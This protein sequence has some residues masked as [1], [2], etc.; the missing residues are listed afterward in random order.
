[1]TEGNMSA[2]W[3]ADYVGVFLT[4]GGTGTF[5]FHYMPAPLEASCNNSWGTL[6]MLKV[7]RDYHVQAYFAQYFAAQVVTRK[8]VQPVDAVHRVFPFS[9]DVRGAPAGQ[10]Q[11]AGPDLGLCSQ[12]SS[13]VVQFR[14]GLVGNERAGASVHG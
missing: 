12:R 2:K 13:R 9:S 5:F 1:M 3:L 8:W 7:D 11:P 4:G 10:C 14:P 6:G